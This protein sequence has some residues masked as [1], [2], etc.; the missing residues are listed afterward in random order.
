VLERIYILLGYW[1]FNAGL[2][3]KKVPT[4]EINRRSFLQRS[5][6]FAAAG[7]FAKGAL[8]LFF[9]APT[10][11]SIAGKRVV[12]LDWDLDKIRK[13][14][15]S[16][17]DTWDPFW[18]DDDHLYSFNCDGRGFGKKPRNMAVNRLDGGSF[19]PRSQ[20]R[21]D[22]PSY[23]SPPEFRYRKSSTILRRI[24]FPIS[25]CS[26]EVYDFA[27]AGQVSPIPPMVHLGA[28]G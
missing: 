13:W 17:G 6:M 18:A 25:F 10:P 23:L 12:E 1:F 14:D 24:H 4:V 26:L 19:N 3:K 16:N 28:L 21:A 9:T 2:K 27:N 22:N 20:P 8:G 7:L 11:K 5:G 15:D